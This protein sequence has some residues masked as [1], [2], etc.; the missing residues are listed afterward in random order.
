MIDD[1]I[2]SNISAELNVSFK[3]VTNVLKLLEDD[4]TIPFIARYRKNLIDSIDEVQIKVIAD[5]FKYQQEIEKRKESIKEIL[6][7]KNLL[8][9]EL[10]EKL[11]SFYTKK[12]LEDFYLPYKE[13]KETKAQ[14]AI[15]MGLEPLALKIYDFTINPDKAM[16]DFLKKNKNLENLA[17]VRQNLIYILS[18]KILENKEIRNLVR[19][20]LYN[21]GSVVSN[22]RKKGETLDQKKNYQIYYSFF[23]RVKAIKNYQILALRRAEENKII[24]YNIQTNEEYLSHKTL[25]LILKNIKNNKN[26][27]KNKVIILDAIKFSLKNSLLP[28]INR[29]IKSELFKRAEASSV[30]IFAKNLE[31]LLLKKPLENKNIL[32]LDPGFRSG[33]KIAVIDKNSNLL[34][35][36]IIY[37]AEPKLDLE[38]A[39]NKIFNY[40][41]EYHINLIVIGNGTAS[42][43]TFDFISNLKLKEIEIST[44]SEVGAS[45]YSASENA[46]KEF[47]NLSLEY[48]SAISIARRIQNPMAELVKIPP[49]AL[50]VGQYQHDINKKFLEDNLNFTMQKNINKV[51]ID[52]NL[53]SKELLMY[54]S[55]ITNSLADKIMKYKSENGLFKNRQ[56]LLNVKGLGA[57]T[58]EQ[59]S[60]FLRI[61]GGT[62]KLDE[63][64]VHPDDYPL[65]KKII[66]FMQ[67]NK[68]NSASREISEK[69][70]EKFDINSIKAYDI[71]NFLFNKNFYDDLYISGYINHEIKLLTKNEIIEGMQTNGE[72]VNILEFG[73]F[74]DIG[75]KTNALI[76]ISEITD[77]FIKNIDDYLSVGEIKKFT[78]KKVD[79]ENEK[80]ELTLKR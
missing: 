35:T 17:E 36:D 69:V 43:E 5:Q 31:L 59:S 58:Y 67:E 16:E 40:V 48:R 74:V 28:S 26:F 11:N 72:I 23:T 71:L 29:E 14:K 77:K 4:N 62:E 55:G 73:A 76:H 6:K 8:T 44:V 53:A 79:L 47:P 50:G 51:G 1:K 27:L 19:D 21:Y 33:C 42:K 68:C 45:V 60:G 54:V 9:K 78:V 22:I 63:T 20:N 80:I 75:F 10:E 25:D 34:K 65:A 30:K 57:K 7:E 24:N 41:E 70:A 37:L 13:K 61:Y 2:V 3:T 18:Q 12:D 38:D 32:G 52:L 49:K 64:F 15:D 39:A 46:K 66:I 56:E